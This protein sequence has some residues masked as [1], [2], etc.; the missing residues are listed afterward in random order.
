M[1]IISQKKEFLKRHCMN[2]KNETVGEKE[3]LI[4]N[5]SSSDA[6]SIPTIL[7]SYT[8]VFHQQ[9]LLKLNQL[10]KFKTHEKNSP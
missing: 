7:S 5:F 6:I 10:L 9:E 1:S 8:F 3:H 4:F 2:Y